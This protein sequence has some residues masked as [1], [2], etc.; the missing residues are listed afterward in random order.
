MGLRE[1][2]GR[3][4]LV[5]GLVL[6]CNRVARGGERV[7][8]LVPVALMAMA[9]GREHGARERGTGILM[10]IESVSQSVSL[11]K[12]THPLCY[13]ASA[14]RHVSVLPTGIPSIHEGYQVSGIKFAREY[15]PVAL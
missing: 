2:D 13:H 11:R 10:S 8:W 3:V 6:V 4:S 7:G 14:A 15:I 12:P 5:F 1:M 9:N